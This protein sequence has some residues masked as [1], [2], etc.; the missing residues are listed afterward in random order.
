MIKVPNFVW[1]LHTQLIF[2]TKTSCN[3]V[4]TVACLCMH[5]TNFTIIIA[6]VTLNFTCIYMQIVYGYEV[7]DVVPKTITVQEFSNNEKS[8]NNTSNL[9]QHH[10]EVTECNPCSNIQRKQQPIISLFVYYYWDCIYLFNM[11]KMVLILFLLFFLLQGRQAFQRKNTH[12]SIA[13]F[14]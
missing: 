3:P 14:S 1:H 13:S 8:N 6:P 2:T 10:L 9:A 12:R 11:V 4:L 7:M 5:S